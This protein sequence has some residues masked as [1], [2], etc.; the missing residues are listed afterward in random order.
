MFIQTETDEILIFN[1]STA[2][3]FLWITHKENAANPLSG[4]NADWWVLT[5]AN[6]VGTN[7]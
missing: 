1:V 7:G 5:N 3:V 6:A 2:G 4:P